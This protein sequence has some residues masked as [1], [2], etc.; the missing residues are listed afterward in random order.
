MSAD[1]VDRTLAAAEVERTDASVVEVVARLH[2]VLSFI[3]DRLDRAFGDLGVKQGEAEVLM[4][5][6]V[7]GCDT[8]SP[9]KVASQLLCS[10]GA[11]T[12][13]LDRLETAGLIERRHDTKDRRAIQLTITAK[14]RK[15]AER[16]MKTRDAI[17]GELLP[18]LTTTDRKTMVRLLRKMLVEFESAMDGE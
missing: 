3:D 17:A 11:M 13:R 6:A 10:T 7:G 9:T 18:G 15:L 16:A 5:L 14:G 12:N 2:R 1:H 4:I 8:Q